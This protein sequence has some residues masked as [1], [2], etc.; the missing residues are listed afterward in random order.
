MKKE[1]KS[2]LRVP[3][4]THAA[5]NYTYL[6]SEIPYPDV[7]ANAKNA[8]VKLYD[9]LLNSCVYSISQPFVGQYSLY[10]IG[11]LRGAPVATDKRSGGKVVRVLLT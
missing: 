2:Q 10:D 6:G 9:H 7:S 8:L 11:N 4:P 5:F 1:K 3:N